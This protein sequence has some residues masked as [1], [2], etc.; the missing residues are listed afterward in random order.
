MQV[1]G[2]D[3]FRACIAEGGYF[4]KLVLNNRVAHFFPHS[5]EH[6]EASLPG[7][8][9]R[10]DSLGDALA[11][12]TKPSMIGIRKHRAI[13]SEKLRSILDRLEIEIGPSISGLFFDVTYGG[14]SIKTIRGNAKPLSNN[15]D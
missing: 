12:T 9:Y 4:L 1:V 8:N 5:T 3:Y 14:E 6:R 2:D 7:L 13:T 11:A 10:D 15:D